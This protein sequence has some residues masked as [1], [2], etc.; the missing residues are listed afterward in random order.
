MREEIENWGR[1]RRRG[2]EDGGG[3]PFKR[4]RLLLRVPQTPEEQMD[5]TF[6]SFSSSSSS[7]YTH[8]HNPRAPAA[9]F[10]LGLF[11]GQVVVFPS[12]FSHPTTDEITT[13]TS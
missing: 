12:Y 8:S 3:P 13:K 2:E 4:G 5:L 1:P 7:P 10:N 11:I 9:G 6:S